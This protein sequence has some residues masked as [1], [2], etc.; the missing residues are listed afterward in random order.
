MKLLGREV[1]N[2]AFPWLQTILKWRVIVSCDQLGETFRAAPTLLFYKVDWLK[3]VVVLLWNVVEFYLLF[4][5]NYVVSTRNFSVK[6][7]IGHCKK[8]Q[9]HRSVLKRGQGGRR[10]ACLPLSHAH[11]P[12]LLKFSKIP[13][14]IF[15]VSSVSVIELG[16]CIWQ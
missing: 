12:T 13:L 8:K 11:T 15:T 9:K 1:T 5:E 14:A 6:C 2:G 3:L 16:Q 4:L 10:G 7:F